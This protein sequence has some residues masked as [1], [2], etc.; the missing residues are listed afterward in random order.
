[1]D[2]C[3]IFSTAPSAGTNSCPPVYRPTRSV[4]SPAHVSRVCRCRCAR[5]RWAR[6]RAT[7]WRP[8]CSRARSGPSRPSPSSPRGSRSRK[9]CRCGPG[10]LRAR[11]QREFAN[12]HVLST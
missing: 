5:R 12:S 3:S 4:H 10:T 7:S 9:P 6:G 11:C 2:Q 1:M 8:L